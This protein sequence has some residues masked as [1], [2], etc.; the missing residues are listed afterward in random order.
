MKHSEK[1]INNQKRLNLHKNQ[2]KIYKFQGRIEGACPVYIPSKS[3][4]SQK[5]IFSILRS[6]LLGGVIMTMT[7]VHSRYLIPTLRKLF[8]FI[9]RKCLACKKYQATSYPV[10]KPGPLRK[11]RTEQCFTFQGTGVNCAG[12]IFHCSTTKKDLKAYILLFSCSVS[13]AL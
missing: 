10:P 12:H 11:A 3:V 5:I 6:T 4:W 1:L 7:K 8:K 2:E 9:I 13:R